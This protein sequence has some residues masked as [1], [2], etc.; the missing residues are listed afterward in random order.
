MFQDNAANA[1]K[2]ASGESR[3]RSQGGGGQPELAGWALTLHMHVDGL[4]A[5][6]TV[7]VESVGA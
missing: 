2:F 7:E 3:D 5:V 4:V 1:C 6:K